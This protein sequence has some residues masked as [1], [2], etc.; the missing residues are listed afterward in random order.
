MPVGQ[1]W[2]LFIADKFPEMAYSVYFEMLYSFPFSNA[3]TKPRRLQAMKF[4]KSTESQL[5]CLIYL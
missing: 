3:P 1:M 2:S 5:I 4:E